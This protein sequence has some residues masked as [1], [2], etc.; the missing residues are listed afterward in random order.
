MGSNLYPT[1][2]FTIWSTSSV[3]LVTFSHRFHKAMAKTNNPS[4]WNLS[5]PHIKTLIDAAP[6][7]KPSAPST[8]QS[9]IGSHKQMKENPPMCDW[10]VDSW[11]RLDRT[12]VSFSTCSILSP[13]ISGGMGFWLAVR[14]RLVLTTAHATANKWRDNGTGKGVDQRIRD[15]RPSH[16]DHE[17]PSSSLLPPGNS[18]SHVRGKRG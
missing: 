18:W 5:V 1:I 13:F 11:Q 2:P 15:V 3:F 12:S 9:H 7:V 6:L 16:V 17:L 14:Q 4:Q 8:H 10:G